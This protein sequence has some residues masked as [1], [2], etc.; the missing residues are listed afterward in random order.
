MHSHMSRTGCDYA[1]VAA[2]LHTG[3]CSLPLPTCCCCCCCRECPVSKAR[4]FDGSD[5]WLITKL[6]DVQ[7]VLQDNRFSKVWSVCSA[8]CS[9]YYTCTVE[10]SKHLALETPACT[11]QEVLQQYRCSKVGAAVCDQLFAASC[12]V[13][14]PFDQRCR[15][16]LRRCAGPR[17]V[18]S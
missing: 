14:H 7:E 15:C 10:Q 2:A 12:Q 5:M 13:H 16:V 6:R 3:M 17:Q 1:R 9:T 11:V 4:L 18:G 8:A